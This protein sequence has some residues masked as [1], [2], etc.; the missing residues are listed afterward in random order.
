MT[1]LDNAVYAV[2]SKSSIIMKYAADTFRSFA[3]DINIE[4]MTDP[5]D[6]VA[7]RHDRQLY[8]ADSSNCIWRV[9]ADD[10]SYSKWLTEL[11]SGEFPVDKLSLTK[12]H[13]LVTSCKRPTVRRYSRT[14]EEP[15]RDVQLPQYVNYVHHAVETTSGNFVVG[16]RGT[17]HSELQH[18]VSELFS[19]CYVLQH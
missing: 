12:E 15:P 6:I 1:Q 11:S 14:N 13:L 16:H 18:A 7:C 8:V 3:E 10:H 19:F 17:L 9:S 2:R 4:G 5:R